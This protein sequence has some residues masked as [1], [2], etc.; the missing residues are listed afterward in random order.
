MRAHLQLKLLQL[1]TTASEEVTNNSHSVGPS[2]GGRPRGNKKTQ[3]RQ[4]NENDLKC[5]KA[6]VLEYSSQ[7]SSAKSVGRKVDYG[8]LDKLIDAK[9][10]EF[11]VKREIS[12]K[13]IKTCL[14]RGT[15]STSHRGTKSPLE[16]VET[17]L[18]QICIQMGK[19]RQPLSCMEAIQLMNNLIH[20]TNT[21]ERLAE[22]QRICNLGS[23]SFKHGLVTQVWWRGFLK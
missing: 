20:Q 10:S 18:V 16:E 15:A 21:Q 17:A 4:D 22:F 19:F 5:I 7:A 14:Y 3:K 6:I 12:K 11:N 8:Y 13:T 23:N 2:T 9:K 1:L